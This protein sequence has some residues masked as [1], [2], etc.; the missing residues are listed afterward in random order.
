MEG[1][2]NSL[3]EFRRFI[4]LSSLSSPDKVASG[5]SDEYRV[6]AV[7]LEG[8]GRR[9]R[10]GPYSKSESRYQLKWSA[11][12]SSVFVRSANRQLLTVSEFT[13]DF[14]SLARATP[15]IVT[16]SPHWTWSLLHTHLQHIHFPAWEPNDSYDFPFCFLF[17]HRLKYHS[18]RLIHHLTFMKRPAGRP[19]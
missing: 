15:G 11:G 7:A 3:L 12:E 6:F 14:S 4:S 5:F 1:C 19:T 8:I 16:T 10:E 17:L 13:A 2:L 18:I 9:S